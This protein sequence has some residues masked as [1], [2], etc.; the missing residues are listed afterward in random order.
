[1][2]IEK[3]MLHGRCAIVGLLVLALI[4]TAAVLQGNVPGYSVYA[5]HFLTTSWG[6][7]KKPSFR[8]LL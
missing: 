7:Q 1:M 5:M 2:I 6:S 3:P 8:E 4:R